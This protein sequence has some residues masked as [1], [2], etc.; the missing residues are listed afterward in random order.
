[1]PIP[2][3]G[4]HAE[5]SYHDKAM[6]ALHHNEP[7][8]LPAYGF[9]NSAHELMGR[10]LSRPAINISEADGL[11]SSLAVL[12]E[13]P[14]MT[15]PNSEMVLREALRTLLGTLH[16][17]KYLLE[18]TQLQRVIRARATRALELSSRN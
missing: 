18:N 11:I 12:T 9:R 1:M 13:C 6:P 7:T 15:K 17:Q 10:I 5:Q 3:F 16:S 8:L 2:D 14:D 4:Q